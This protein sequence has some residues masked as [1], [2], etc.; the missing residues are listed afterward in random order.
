MPIYEYLCPKCRKI[1]EEWAASANDDTVEPC[2][3]C[4]TPASRVM[5]QTSFVLKGDGWYVSDY[6]YRKG[7]KE[8][9]KEA[10]NAA[11]RDADRETAKAAGEKAPDA[12]TPQPP[13][14]APGK[15]REAGSPPESAA[16]SVAA[17]QSA[18]A[19]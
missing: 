2:P 4:A 8:D 1:F 13:E 18:A 12:A 6:G 15:A 17:R 9:G 14:A 16:K 19:P 3:R 11:G 10:Q 5:S 7:I